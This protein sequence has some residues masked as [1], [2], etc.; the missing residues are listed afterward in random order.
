MLRSPFDRL[1]ANGGGLENIEN[2]PFVLSSSKHEHHFFSILLA[3]LAL[4]CAPVH[5]QETFSGMII[6]LSQR[7]RAR[8]R[9]PRWAEYKP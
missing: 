3:R 5:D 6:S 1:R 8:V 2:C 7:E 9:E 4:K